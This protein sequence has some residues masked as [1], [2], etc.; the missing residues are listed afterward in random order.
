MQ[1]MLDR[2]SDWMPPKAATALVA[3]LNRQGK[4]RLPDMWE[5]VFLDALGQVAAITYE[6]PLA[7]GACPDFQF[8]LTATDGDITV[9]GD[10]TT[11]SDSGIDARNPFDALTEAVRDRA[12]KEGFSG[13]GF[14]VEVG[15]D[16]IGEQANRKVQLAIPSGPAFEQL[17]RHHIKPFVQRVARNQNT[18]DTLVVNEAGARFTIRYEGPSD[19]A[20]GSHRT[21][22]TALS[23]TNNPIYNQLKA[24]AKQLRG[25][26]QEAVRLLIVCDGDCATMSRSAPL[27][28][29]SARQIAE[30]FL[31]STSSVDLVLLASVEEQNIGSWWTRRAINSR[32]ELVA[33]VAPHRRARLTDALL[34]QS[35][36][37]LQSAI[38][39]IP[40]PVMTPTNAAR[41]N[42][43]TE[44][45][46]SMSMALKSTGNE[47]RISA[48]A[49]QE[50]L[51]G[52]KSYERFAEE[53]GWDTGQG[54]VFRGQLASGR[55]FATA[56]IEPGDNEDD[57]WIVFEF[58]VPDPSVSPFRLPRASRSNPQAE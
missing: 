53:H 52:T 17:V 56:R 9:V 47:V 12:V 42:V 10:I 48:R 26:P 4:N 3:R 39:Q 21:Y 27:E 7:T 25:A 55:L 38:E 13:G 35:G 34:S 37:M 50:L 15:Y 49:L 40:R 44:V 32:Y 19:F 2:C 28:G 22:D 43:E 41:R 33:A 36:Q 57:D 58:G 46:A 6:Q 11:V 24:K 30:R 45:G 16:E 23:I 51:A 14:H 1:S 8:V 18:P 31:Q 20:G 5:L 29:F 54:N